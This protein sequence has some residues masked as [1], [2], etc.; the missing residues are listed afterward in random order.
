MIR[1]KGSPPSTF[2]QYGSSQPLSTS[3]FTTPGSQGRKSH[4]ATFFFIPTY[5]DILEFRSLAPSE[6][7]DRR[8]GLQSPVTLKVPHS[9]EKPRSGLDGEFIVQLVGHI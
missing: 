4:R 5:C 9:V 8:R 2:P 3:T 7:F 1:S 6:S